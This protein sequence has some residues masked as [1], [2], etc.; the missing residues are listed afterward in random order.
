MAAF[1]NPFETWNT[2]FAGEGF[3]RRRTERIP[4]QASTLDEMATQCLRCRWKRSKRRLA[5]L[6]KDA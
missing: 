2:R 3:V 1:D 6:Y 5:W 4:P